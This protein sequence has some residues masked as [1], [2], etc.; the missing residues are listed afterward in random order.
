MSF[1]RFYAFLS[2]SDGKFVNFTRIFRTIRKLLVKNSAN[3]S[4]ISVFES[5][6]SAVFQSHIPKQRH[7]LPE[8]V[9]TNVLLLARQS[10]YN[11]GALG[12]RVRHF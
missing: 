10:A 6:L 7:K 2:I 8:R 3:K 1:T 12:L 9:G 11:G 4:E 5:T